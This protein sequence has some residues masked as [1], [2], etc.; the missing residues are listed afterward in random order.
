MNFLFRILKLILKS[1]L[2]FFELFFAFIAS[3]VLIS[4][5]FMSIKVGEVS[6]KK[7]IEIFMKSDGIHTDFVFPVDSKYRKQ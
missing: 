7:G 6:N 2:I 1:G 4:L 5:F 3:Y